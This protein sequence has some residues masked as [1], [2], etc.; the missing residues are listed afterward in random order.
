M[1]PM[2]AGEARARGAR[3]SGIIPSFAPVAQLDRVPGYEPGGRGFKSCRA[4]HYN[5]W[6]RT[7]VLTH[8]HFLQAHLGTVL[9][10]ARIAL[11]S[12]DSASPTIFSFADMYPAIVQNG[13][14]FVC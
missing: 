1:M 3:D 13:Y 2:P 12:P 9:G 7:K 4:R 5:Q 11:G 8:F 10:T 14:P 6:V